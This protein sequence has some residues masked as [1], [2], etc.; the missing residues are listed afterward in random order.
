MR[1]K[2][3]VLAVAFIAISATLGASAYTTGSVSR[4]A[5][6]SV[7]N[8]DVGLIA[9]SD[10]TSGPLVF[11][12]ASGALEIDFTKGGASGV[13][14]ASHYELGNPADAVNQSAFNITN[15][16]AEAHDLTISYTGAAL[17]DADANIEFT[18]Y[19]SSGAVA[20]TVSEESTSATISGAA[21]GSTYYVVIVVDTYGVQSG[22]NLS[23]TLKVSA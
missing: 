7:V 1:R 4:S 16:D 2:F 23:G 12:N 19:D 14:T 17:G 6:I 18:V 3:T 22:T 20:A 21:A 11:Q 10:G 9:L 15:N 8:D 5:N 13:N